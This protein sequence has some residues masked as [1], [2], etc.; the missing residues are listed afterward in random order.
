MALI[1]ICT[2]R[3]GGV[4]SD[5]PGGRFPGRDIVMVA[6]V[7]CEEIANEKYSLFAKSQDWCDL[8]GAVK[9]HI[10]PGFGRKLS[11]MID[12]CLSSYD[13]EATYFEDSVRSAKRK[14]LEEKLIQLVHPTYQ[15]LLEHIQLETLDKFKTSLHDALNGGFGFAN[16]ARDCSASF[17][18]IFEEQCKDATVKQADW[19]SVKVRDKFSHDIDS[20]IAEVRTAKLSELNALYESKL[21]EALD[22]PVGAL[23]EG[24]GDDTWPAIRKLFHH[25]IKRAVS[26]FSVA[27]SG[28]EMDEKTNEEMLLKLEN[29]ARGIVEG[30]TKEEAGRALYRMKERFTSLFNHDSD[31]MPRIWTG[32][33]DIRTI[34]KTARS[35]SLKLLSVLAAIRLDEDVDKIGDTLV[36]ALVNQK[37]ETSTSVSLRDPLASSTWEEV[38]ATKT[39]IT[40]VQCK[41]LWSQFQRETEYTITQAIASQEANKRNNN[42]LPPPW[43]IAA[44]AIL[45]F[46][47]FMTLLRNPLWLLVIFVGY[48]LSKAL[49]VQ[50]DISGEFRNGML[51]GILSL[52]TK[53][54]PTVTNLLRKLAEEGQ[55]PVSANS[56]KTHSN[57]PHVLGNFQGVE[58]STGS[59]NVTMENGPEYTSP[60]RHVKDQ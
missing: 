35:S 11:S 2:P 60:S 10:V 29:Y 44:L 37:K 18:R 41:S 14:Q 22:G 26:E 38:P 53:F 20:H 42:W 46:N 58:S 51:P 6:T 1:P 48:L 4:G 47:E 3:A 7:R 50:L 24:G 9:S 5:S 45:G 31:S 23:L 32:K 21:K 8:E 25:E 27:L 55:K 40:P 17:I 39:L 36:L 16:A 34:T 12:T 30:K 56:E 15:V 59:S 28:F 57:H 43:A 19:D 13:E 54:L 33:E 49:W 52:S